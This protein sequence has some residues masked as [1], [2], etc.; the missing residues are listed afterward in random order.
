LVLIDYFSLRAIAKNR[1]MYMWSD[2]KEA[3]F[4]LAPPR[5]ERNSGFT[6]KELNRIEQI[7]D[8]HQDELMRKW[9][10]FFDQGFA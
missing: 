9:N 8:D 5:L 3:K 1:R 2:D 6:R 7:I 10:E 4:W